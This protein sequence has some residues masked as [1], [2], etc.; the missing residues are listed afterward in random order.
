[1]GTCMGIRG[2]MFSGLSLGKPQRPYDSLLRPRHSGHDA[3]RSPMHSGRTAVTMVRIASSVGSISCST[4]GIMIW[5]RY[6]PTWNN[7][8]G[9]SY[10]AERSDPA[11]QLS[12]A[13]S[14]ILSARA[15]SSACVWMGPPLKRG[16]SAAVSS[17]HSCCNDLS[18]LI[19][20]RIG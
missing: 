4:A 6:L 7:N 1:M 8:G 15:C 14:M 20:D 12:Q 19:R 3:S 5:P 13:R 16:R 9:F 17:H 11:P 18:Y 10:R 2:P